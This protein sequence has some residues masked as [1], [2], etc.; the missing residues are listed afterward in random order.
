MGC[1]TQVALVE[2]CVTQVALVEGCV[3]QV[4]PINQSRVAC[5]PVEG[6]VAQVSSGVATKGGNERAP[7]PV[8]LSNHVPG[9]PE[10][11]CCIILVGLVIFENH[12][13]TFCIILVGDHFG[14]YK[15]SGGFGACGALY[16]FG[17]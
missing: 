7:I 16:H 12:P 3:T 15:I 11:F 4:V 2:G 17:G 14:G 6:C 13:K 10:S 8:S 1:M 5:A 9:T